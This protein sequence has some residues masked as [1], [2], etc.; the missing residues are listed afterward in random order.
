MHSKTNQKVSE[1]WQ[2]YPKSDQNI[3]KTGCQKLMRNKT[4]APLD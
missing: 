2:M 4:T 1:E 3:S